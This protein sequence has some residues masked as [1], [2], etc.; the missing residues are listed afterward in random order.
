M[1]DMSMAG[2][3]SAISSVVKGMLQF[4]DVNNDDNSTS[5][6]DV[7]YGS[8]LMNHVNDLRKT[9]KCTSRS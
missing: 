8:K 3:S 4:V 7:I 1:F 2:T 5:H 9:D 6:I